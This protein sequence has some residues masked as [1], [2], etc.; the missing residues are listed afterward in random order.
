MWILAFSVV[1]FSNLVNDSTMNALDLYLTYSTEMVPLYCVVYFFCTDVTP[2]TYKKGKLSIDSST[3][4]MT[5]C[6]VPGQ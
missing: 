6:N 2:C 5:N 1:G 4:L 3:L